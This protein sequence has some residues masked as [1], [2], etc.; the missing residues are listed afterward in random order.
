MSNNSK[1]QYQIDF[2]E[3]DVLIDRIGNIFSSNANPKKLSK[4]KWQYLCAPGGKSYSAF[5]VSGTGA[6]AAVY[7]VFGVKA[8]INGQL[9]LVCQSLDTLTDRD[10]RG[11]GLFTKIAQSTFQ[12]CDE[13][14]VNFVYGFPNSS[15]APGF[16]NK[17]GWEEI[18]FP[19]FLF[20]LNNL[21]YPLSYVLKK[22]GFYLKNYFF[23]FLLWLKLLFSSKKNN[24]TFIDEFDFSSQYDGIWEK[25][26]ASINT[27]IWRDSHYMKWR[28]LQRPESDYLFKS[29]YQNNTLIGVVVYLC[30]EKHGGRV[31]YIMDIIYDPDHE[32]AAKLLNTYALLDLVKKRVDIVLAWSSRDFFVNRVFS[33]TLF[34]PMPRKI[35]P[36]KLFFGYRP[37][38]ISPIKQTKKD[39]Y[40]SYADS[41]TV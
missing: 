36:I 25:F 10:H 4:L 20:Y 38:E 6:D 14:G 7:S 8:K 15:S 3:Q 13:D 39:F 17:L 24:Y 18:G 35:Q 19:P 22:E 33:S 32:A 11:K 9:G 5:A 34:F 12:K 27:C 2:P 29:V 31:G 1:S 37:N 16:F 23:V 40:L 41:D 21:L 26:S 28:Y 30:V